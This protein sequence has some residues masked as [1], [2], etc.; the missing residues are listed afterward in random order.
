[1]FDHVGGPVAVRQGRS[2]R[3][4]VALR[5]NGQGGIVSG[6]YRGARIRLAGMICAGI[7]LVLTAVALAIGLVAMYA[8]G[9]SFTG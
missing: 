1:M 6:Q 4:R 7:A 8:A 3:W 2:R 5:G 9:A